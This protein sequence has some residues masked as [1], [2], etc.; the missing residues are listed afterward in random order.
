MSWW[1]KH[2][3]CVLV[4]VV[5][6]V[7]VL[8]AAYIF[9]TRKTCPGRCGQIKCGRRSGRENYSSNFFGVSLTGSEDPVW[10]ISWKPPT[11]GTGSGYNVTYSGTMTD[12][13]GQVVYKF[14]NISVTEFTLP[15]TTP[16]GTYTVSVVATNQVGSGPSYSQKISLTNHTP[17]ISTV[18]V[19]NTAQDLSNIKVFCLGLFPDKGN[20]CNSQNNPCNYTGKIVFTDYA[21]HDTL[22]AA[23]TWENDHD[24]QQNVDEFVFTVKFA[25]EPSPGQKIVFD[26]DI[27]NYD[28]CATKS[29]TWQAPG[30]PP[31]PSTSLQANFGKG[32]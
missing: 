8:L 22:S 9:L 13:K 10:T 32:S 24:S 19:Q 28:L 31:G 16:L 30:I 6:A 29:W 15:D 1:D 20:G 23:Y 17:S 21:T 3:S 18:T 27:C 11:Q 7:F 5:A 12:D 4:S 26:I 25:K 2:W 14:T